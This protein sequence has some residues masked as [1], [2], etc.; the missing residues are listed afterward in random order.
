MNL[1]NAVRRIKLHTTASGGMNSN[2]PNKP[3]TV[4][5]PTNRVRDPLILDAVA[6]PM[7]RTAKERRRD[8]QR[9]PMGAP[10]TIRV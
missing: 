4:A 1:A 9:G 6:S 3:I 7:L 8:L 10:S 5:S 2:A